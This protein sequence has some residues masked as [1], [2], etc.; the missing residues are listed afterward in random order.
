MGQF[1][2]CQGKSTY[3]CSVFK[4]F[5]VFMLKRIF[6]KDHLG[7]TILSLLI[8]WFFSVVTMNLTFF[9]P[10]KR[11]YDNFSLSDMYYQ[12]IQE[13]SEE[14]ESPIITIV[15]LTTLYDRGRIAQ[16][17]DDVNACEPSVVGIDIMFEGLKGDTIGSEMLVEA[18]CQIEQPVIAYKL[19]NVNLETG[20]FVSA[21]HSFFAPIDGLQEGYTNVQHIDLGG[22]I[23]NMSTWHILNQ[24]TVYSLSYH[25]AK[26]FSPDISKEHFPRRQLIDYTPTK[27]PVVP[28]DSIFEYKDKITN[29]IV[30]LGAMNDDADMHYSPYGRTA[31]TNIQAYAVQTMLEHKNILEVGFVWN[32]L[33]S[34]LV[35]VIVDI[36]QCEITHHSDNSRYAI[37]QFLFSS[38]IVKNIINFILIAFLVW[39]NFIVFIQCNVYFNPTIM[40]TGIAFLVEAR[41][42]YASGKATYEKIK[43]KKQTI[44]K[45]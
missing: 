22:I 12:I 25:V 31:G 4:D 28:Y 11:A 41:L 14:Q 32:I 38:A 2:H 40:L 36:I 10:I 6:N 42:F 18:I 24:D 37:V 27:F 35:L 3:I 5:F 33:I 7:V 1:V 21:R 34:I 9:D 16:V 30:L 13:S 29:R 17:I 19:K 43:Q 15:D 39:V 45:Q 8:V 20:E 26:A 44:I 23:R